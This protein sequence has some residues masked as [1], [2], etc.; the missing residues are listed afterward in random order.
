[1][2]QIQDI[3][4]YLEAIAPSAYQESYDNAR[5]IVGNPSATVSGILVSLDAIESVVDEAIAKQCNMIVS[6]HPIVFS[7]LKSLT[8]KNYVERTVIKAIKHDIALYAIHT[9]LD[10]VQQGV[11]RMLSEKLGLQN[12]RILAPKANT[13]HKLVTFVPLA[14][15][16]KVLRALGKAGAGQI[17][18]YQNCSF[19]TPGTGTFQPNEKADPHIGKAGEQEEVAEQR[20]EVMYPAHLSTHVLAALR[21][22]HPYEEGRLLSTSS[23]QRKPGGRLR[24]DRRTARA[25]VRRQ[26]SD[27]SKGKNATV[28]CS[29]YPLARHSDSARSS[30][31]WSRKLLA[32]ARPTATGRCLCNSR[33]Q[34]P[35]VF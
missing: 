31:R 33:L 22:A 16:D 34:I 14:D 25:A 28:S 2:P 11:N 32:T 17:G 15:T 30:V 19:R 35:R 10:N 8:G 21:S 5:L 20:V 23:P 1:M 18:N 4:R 12:L 27:L 29:P 7:G 3:T 13:L 26:V 6:H 9:N 24:H